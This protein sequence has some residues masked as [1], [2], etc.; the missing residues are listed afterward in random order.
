[1][2]MSSP[3]TFT[4]AQPDQLLRR[5]LQIDGLTALAAGALWC[6]T[7]EKLAALTQLPAG[8]IFYAGLSFLPLGIYMLL[9]A[10][11][12]PPHRGLALSIVIGNFAWAIASF[13]LLIGGVAEPNAFGVA[14]VAGQAGWVALLAVLEAIGLRRIA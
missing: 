11:Q 6:A 8:L 5:A 3:E 7:S 4:T 2:T 9:I 13:A 12:R 14:F 1:M 10:S